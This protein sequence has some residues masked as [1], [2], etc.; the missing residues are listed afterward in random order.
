MNTLVVYDSEHGDTFEV[1]RAVADDLADHGRTRLVRVDDVSSQDLHEVELLVVGSP[2]QGGK[3]TEKMQEF[4]TH[5][6]DLS[7]LQAAAFDT[8]YST[9][10]HGPALSLLM[11]IIGYASEKMARTLQDKGAAMIAE[12]T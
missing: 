2:N 11:H 5:I 1:A 7:G 3:P 10:G 4:L 12:P 9:R 8:R 6:P